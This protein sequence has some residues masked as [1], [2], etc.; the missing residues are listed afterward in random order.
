MLDFAM[1]KLQK[2]PIQLDY[3]MTMECFLIHARILNDFFYGLEMRLSNEKMLMQDDIIAEDIV[4]GN[5]WQK[6]QV[7]RLPSQ[8]T[9]KINNQLTHLTY[10]REPGKYGDWDFE[11]IY[12]RMSEL[13]ELF[14]KEVN[15]EQKN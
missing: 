10:N 6:P 4:G 7:N 2:K 13:V 3:A 15:S 12:K 9:R 8:L 1:R 14:F 5:V 11:D